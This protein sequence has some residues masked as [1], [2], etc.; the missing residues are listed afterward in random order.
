MRQNRV[1]DER[2][3]ARVFAAAMGDRT[4]KL[5]ATYSI[6]ARDAATGELGVAVASRYLAVGAYVPMVRAGVGAVASQA[7]TNLEWRAAALDLLAAGLTPE[8]ASAELQAA[9]PERAGR[10][11]GIVA[12]DGASSSYTGLDCIDWAGGVCGPDFAVQGNILAG[13]AVVNAMVEAFTASAGQTLAT[14][15]LGVLE[16]GEE[17]GGD[18]RGRQAAALVIAPPSGR[19]GDLRVDDHPEPLTELA[20][21]LELWRGLDD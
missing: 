12:A 7:H 1:T 5:I 6:A 15:L 20:R 11:L 10:Q 14:R 17:A 4:A 16:A 13:P 2:F 3:A 8:Q 19:T 18:S 21:L 9:D